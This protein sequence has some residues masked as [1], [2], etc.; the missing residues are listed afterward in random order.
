MTWLIL[1]YKVTCNDKSLNFAP[2]IV[3][4]Y[5]I[6]NQLTA[7][8]KEST[9]LT[10]TEP[11]FSAPPTNQDTN[12]RNRNLILPLESLR[13]NSRIHLPQ[14]SGQST[15]PHHHPLPRRLKMNQCTVVT[16]LY[17]HLHLMITT[18]LLT[19]NQT[20]QCSPRIKVVKASLA[21]IQR[22]MAAD[23]AT[24]THTHNKVMG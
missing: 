6:Q 2:K 7:L 5:N 12:R 16:S 4:R 20:H 22:N 13:R 24:T 8:V 23:M 19:L 9:K 15:L 21:I 11:K 3:Y 10:P 18:T 14:L 1:L 17:P